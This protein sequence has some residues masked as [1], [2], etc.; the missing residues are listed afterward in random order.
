MA[1][2]GSIRAGG[3][4]RG[5][6]ASADHISASLAGSYA[7]FYAEASG[8]LKIRVLPSGEKSQVH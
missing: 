8:L 4:G 5:V 3:G 2:Y 6:S 7:D 1:V